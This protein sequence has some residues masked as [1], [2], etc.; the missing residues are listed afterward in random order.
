MKTLQKLILTPQT[1]GLS[2]QKIKSLKRKGTITTL[3]RGA[4]IDSATFAGLSQ[5]EQETLKVLACASSLYPRLPVSH[6]S[7]ALLVGLDL[8]KFDKA[9]HFRTAQR[10]DS[11]HKEIK[12]HFYQ[13]PLISTYQDGVL[14][15]TIED[16]ILDCAQSLPFHEALV[17][18]DSAL[19]KQ[20]TTQDKLYTA[21]S[22]L[23]M[24]RN[25][26]GMADVLE[27][28]TNISG[29]AGE[30][31]CRVALAKA[32]LKHPVLQ[33]CF[34]TKSGTFY[35]D[36]YFPDKKLIVEF[37]G[38]IKYSGAYGTPLDTIKQ[39]KL[40]AEALADL[41]L[42]IVRFNWHEIH[43]PLKVINKLQAYFPE[44]RTRITD[45]ASYF[46]TPFGYLR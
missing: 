21:F 12:L 40:R 7:A 9:V 35:T 4:Y 38:D 28:C 37:D 31:L 45:S 34:D 26:N 29:S 44:V 30:T 43:D 19:R 27:N 24:R 41:G 13:T 17:I 8:Y 15:T 18:A 22:L 14:I 2:L 39:E 5:R 46:F 6:T 36:F 11:K 42:R 3:V 25:K 32:G 1:A 10:R 20:L 23:S 33:Q 16:T